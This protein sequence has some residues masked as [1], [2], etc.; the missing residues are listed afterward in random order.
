MI[1]YRFY[2]IDAGNRV[3]TG[4]SAECPSDAAA[5][6]AAR[7]LGQQRAAVVE[8]WQAKRLVGCLSAAEPMN[9][10]RASHHQGTV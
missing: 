8:V 3:L 1:D 5:M 4:Y 9:L 6:E 7:R 2:E 10:W